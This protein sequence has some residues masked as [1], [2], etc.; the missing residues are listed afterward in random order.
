MSDKKRKVPK[1]RFPG[2]TDAWEQR[3]LGEMSEKMEYG[4]NA[5]AME[6]DGT[7]KYLRITDIDEETRE[8]TK[9]NLTSPRINLS[10]SAQYLLARKDILFARTGASVGKT[11]CYR[12]E[13]GDVY[14]AGFLIRARIKETFDE[15]FIFQYTLTK[16]YSDYINVTSQRSGQ[17]GVNANEYSNLSILTPNLSE[18]EKIGLM[19]RKIDSYISLHQR[20]LDNVKMLKKSLL[21]KLFP[22][23]GEKTPELRFPGFTDAWEQR[24]LGEVGSLLKETVYPSKH[25]DKLYHEYS[26]PN[27]DD[28]KTPKV[29]K[30][31]SMLSNRIKIKGNV[32]L[33]NKLNVHQRRIWNVQTSFEDSVASGEFLPYISEEVNLE[34]LSQVL[35]SDSSTLDLISLSSGSSNSQKRITPAEFMKYNVMFPTD[36]KEQNM[37]AKLLNSIDKHISLHQRKLDHLKELKKGLLQQMFV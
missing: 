30:G 15:E 23:D 6:Y 1:L 8:F 35:L 9:T 27:Y 11:Y 25:P 17:P 29:V 16:M 2:F 10:E 20:K 5:P 34:M 12:E 24:K 37:I 22:K 14:F 3:K 31:N 13:D 21:Q 33:I 36:I 28:W 26:M 7:N 19:L 18:Q 4:L 32:L